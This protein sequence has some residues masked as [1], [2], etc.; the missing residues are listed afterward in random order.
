MKI[1]YKTVAV[2]INRGLKEIIRNKS[3]SFFRYLELEVANLAVNTI[4]AQGSQLERI[5]AISIFFISFFTEKDFFFFHDFTHHRYCSR[6]RNSKKKKEKIRIKR[7]FSLSYK[8]TFL[9]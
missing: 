9:S 5:D 7:I 1:W 8:S 6:C 2:I 4:K 3:L